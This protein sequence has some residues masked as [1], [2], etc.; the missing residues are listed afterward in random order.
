MDFFLLFLVLLLSGNDQT[1]K[2]I[3]EVMKLAEITEG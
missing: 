1:Q 3:A 2:L